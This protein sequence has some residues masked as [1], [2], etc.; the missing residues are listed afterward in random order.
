ME[1]NQYIPKHGFRT[2]VSIAHRGL[3]ATLSAIVKPSMARP[4]FLHKR[5]S[6]AL[7]LVVAILTVIELAGAAS[8]GA[9]ATT[10]VPTG[11]QPSPASPNAAGAP[12]LP[13]TCPSPSFTGPTNFA[14]GTGPYS[15]AVG[16]FNRDG[17]ADLVT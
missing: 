5:W 10:D 16:D 6:L 13:D 12:N 9:S 3:I 17:I 14:A 8:V 7:G 15:V 11:S 1:E 2:F 4:Q